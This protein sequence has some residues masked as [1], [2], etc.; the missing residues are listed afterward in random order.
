MQARTK[1]GNLYRTN[2]STK[3]RK[4]LKLERRIFVFNYLRKF[5]LNKK[6]FPFKLK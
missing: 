5:S 3:I 6:L 1:E 2:D 4:E